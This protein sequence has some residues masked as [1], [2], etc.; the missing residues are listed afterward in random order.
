VDFAGSP[1]ATLTADLLA[2]TLDALGIDR[3]AVV[4]GSIGNLW[5]LRFAQR[6]PSR[7]ERIVLLGGGPISPEVGVPTFIRLLRSPVG[8]I[9]VRIPE[10]RGMLRKQLTSLG[11]GESLAAGR[12]PEAFLSWHL[13]LSRS[14]HWA[15]HERDMVRAVVD[16]RGYVPGLVLQPDETSRIVQPTLM[17]YGSKDPIGSVE[18]W[19]RFIEPMPHGELDVVDGGG[20]LVWFDD[21]D[22]VG[23]RLRGFLA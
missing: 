22:R 23:E 8:R 15:K 9:M 7:V 6:H 10:G 2:Q 1:Y 20:H 17:V 4:A 11:H 16:R 5:A 19:R 3:V 18:V 21:P 13:V 12:F 14:T